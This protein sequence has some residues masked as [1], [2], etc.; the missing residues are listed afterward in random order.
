MVNNISFTIKCY[1]DSRKKG[2]TC[3]NGC[4]SF[5]KETEVMREEMEGIKVHGKG[6]PKP[7]REWAQVGVSKK[8]L[9]CLKK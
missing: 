6:C 4:C 2:I 8:V 1:I 7:V 9:E 5:V 3:T